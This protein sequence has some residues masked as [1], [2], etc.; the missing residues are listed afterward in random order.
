MIRAVLILSALLLLSIP[1]FAD[2]RRT[3]KVGISQNPPIA[4]QHPDG[5][6]EGLAVDVMNDIAARNE[7]T[8]EYVQDSWPR[9]L[10][11]LQKG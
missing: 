5:E 4:I 10:E 2:H 8:L 7:W 11:R 6:P 1:A 9:L 3:M